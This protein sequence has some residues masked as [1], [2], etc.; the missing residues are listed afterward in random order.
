MMLYIHVPF[1]RHKCVYCDFMS[2]TNIGLRNEYIEGLRKE[3][4]NV[5]STD[6][7]ACSFS[8]PRTLY[9]GGGTPS[10]LSLNEIAEI[11]DIVGR[12]KVEEWTI[13]CNPEDMT[14]Q[15]LAGIRRLG[16]SRLSVGVQSLNDDELKWMERRHT[17]ADAVNA[18]KLA[19]SLGFNNISADVIFG[20][21]NQS[22]D[23]VQS[24]IRGILSLDLQHLSLYSLMFEEGSKITM[25]NVEPIDDNI[26]AEMFRMICNEL[27]EAGYEHYEISNWAKPGFRARHNYGY[28][29]GEPYMGLGPAAH[30][31]D[32]FAMRRANVANTMKW[33]K[34]EKP[35][36]EHL[37][38]EERFNERVML[39]LR[40]ADGI[41][42]AALRNDFPEEWVAQLEND[43]AQYK[44]YLTYSREII[45]LFPRGV[46]VSDL[47]MQECMRI[48]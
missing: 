34:G 5:K 36:V 13:E 32:G 12:P 21:P 11:F 44:Q 33:L 35:E 16:V 20:L 2:G 48:S 46:F 3:W 29:T 6:D 38:D 40:T 28:W 26:A 19:Q 42:V 23:S 27:S 7:F 25:K 14:E 9:F 10:I 24:T 43:L 30:S 1:C 15:W 18:I 22:V 37:T 39:G 47:I 4:L 45:S 41:D 17:A 31:F 8:S